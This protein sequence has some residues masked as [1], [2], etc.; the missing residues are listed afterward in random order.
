M[1]T[2]TYLVELQGISKRFGG[3]QALQGVSFGIPQ[4]RIHGLVGENGAGKSTLIKILGGVHT[5]DEGNVLFDGRPFVA[6]SPADSLKA[7]I[8][9]VHQELPL[10]PNLTV[11]QNV[12]LRSPV[13]TRF[14]RM[15]W[16]AMNEQTCALFQRIGQ[17]V[18]PEAPVGSLSVAEQQL[19]SIVK[20]LRDDCRLLIMD[21][22]TAAL[23][24]SEVQ[25][26]FGVLR[27]LRDQGTTI[28]F[29]SHILSEVFELTD[30]LTVLRNGRH[31]GTYATEDVA[32]RDVVQMMVGRDVREDV[33]SH[34]TRTDEKP[35]LKVEGL[36]HRR[37]GLRDISFELYPGEILGIAGIQG[38]GRTELAQCLFGVHPP[39]EGR[40]ILEGRP[41]RFNSPRDAINHG[42]GY[43]VEDRRN[44]GLFWE[45][46]VKENMVAAIVD[47]VL[48]LIGLMDKKKVQ[49]LG[50]QAVDRLQIRTESLEQKVQFLSGGNQ[51]KALL[52]RWLNVEPRILIL[53][54]PTRGVDVGAKSE[55]R[56]VIRELV[57]GGLSV[58]V[59]SSDLEELLAISDRVLV[60]GGRRIQ[61][62]LRADQATMEAVMALA[63]VR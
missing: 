20:A 42:I 62:V 13:T 2:P 63:T 29:V 52:A 35:I 7:G 1:K 11:A 22:P 19:T 60:M 32:V 56:R 28:I 34:G 61:G 59:I 48:R 39:D 40:V 49:S 12:F 26:L 24:P 6:R 30:T 38:A 31:V 14:G 18:D 3:V 21:E 47:R 44:L 57:D 55:I 45:L 36:S 8:N 5:C 54:E 33:P 43:L 25:N 51:Q 16:N 58:I 53:D 9:I 23:T 17:S 15:D 50:E 4:G 37:S 46:N 10:C 27:Q 41:V